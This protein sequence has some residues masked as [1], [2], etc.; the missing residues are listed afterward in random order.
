M[1][2]ENC[3]RTVTVGATSVSSAIGALKITCGGASFTTGVTTMSTGVSAGAVAS[4]RDSPSIQTVPPSFLTVPVTS[5][6][7]PVS[8]LALA[9]SSKFFPFGRRLL[10]QTAPSADCTTKS[11]RLRFEGGRKIAEQI[12]AAKP[13][14]DRDA[15]VGIPFRRQ[16]DRAQ[17]GGHRQ[18]SFD[19]AGGEDHVD[20]L[21]PGPSS[22][23]RGFEQR[24]EV[25]AR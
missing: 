6:Q 21:A 8:T 2:R 5:S 14:D 4:C 15:A 7:R 1:S 24:L 9:S 23:C 10:T 25:V 3:T 19:Q 12:A 13:S 18:G 17:A 11:H 22:A 20:L 16:R